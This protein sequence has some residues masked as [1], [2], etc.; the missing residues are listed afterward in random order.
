MLQDASLNQFLQIL[1]NHID[2]TPAG[3]GFV[4]QYNARG[5]HP[6]FTFGLALL[7]P[8]AKCMLKL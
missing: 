4:R 6:Y 7:V 8:P 1:N 3:L 2:M 5:Y